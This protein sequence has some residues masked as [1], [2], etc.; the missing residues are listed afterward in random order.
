MPAGQWWRQAGR[1]WRGPLT[2]VG[3]LGTAV[4]IAALLAG[5]RAEF[6]TALG[7]APLGVLALVAAM[8][9]VAL[10][11]RS[12]AWHTSVRAAGGTVSRRRLFRA[13]STGFIGSLLN[14]QLGAA[15]RIATLRRSAQNECPR[16]RTLLTAEMPIVAV[17]AVLAVLCSFTLVAPLGIPW[18]APLVALAVL[19]GGGAGLRRFMVRKGRELWA[20]LAVVRCSRGGPRVVAF[21]VVSV[22]LQVLRNWLVLHALGI[23]ASL[24]DATAVLIAM[25]TLMALPV[26][27]GVGV[28]AVVLI[29]GSQGVGAVGAAGVLLTATGLA[30]GLA[31]ALW[32]VLDWAWSHTRELPHRR[33]G[34]MLRA[35]GAFDAGGRRR[36]ELAYFGGLSQLQVARALQV[37]PV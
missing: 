5:H 12:E 13:A 29:L 28:G 31:F 7:A 20:G 1:R 24:L 23:N 10:L 16:V 4:G 14:G 37:L 34:A 15:V 32:A 3:I 36:I 19:L 2:F 27:P 8:Q 25:V 18:W 22:S 9:T 11:A 35:L 17:E 26:G 6:T 21:V 30:G 33:T